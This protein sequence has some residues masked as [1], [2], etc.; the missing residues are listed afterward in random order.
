ME[1][2]NA[3]HKSDGQI[4][5]SFDIWTSPNSLTMIGVI[6]YWIDEKQQLQ[7][8]LLGLRQLIGQHSG[9]NMAL[10]VLEIIKDFEIGSRI[11]HFMADNVSSNDTCIGE[12]A[13]HLGNRFEASER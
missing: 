8:A 1:L 7:T 13:K 12:M 3:F 4:H 11:G 2:R 6:A 5:F 9:E 10:K